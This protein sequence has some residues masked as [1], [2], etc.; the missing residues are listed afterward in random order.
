M[1][2]LF[3]TR[4]E[5]GLEGLEASI[6]WDHGC[7]GVVEEGPELVAWFDEIV[8]LPLEGTWE[9][10]PVVDYV[11]H[12]YAGL[13]PVRVGRLLIAP[14]HSSV[15]L[16]CPERPLWIDPGMAFGSGHHDTTVS[17]LKRLD[18]V[19]LSGKRV[20]DVGSG[21]GILAIA[22]D[23]LGA[24]SVLGVDNDAATLP[25]ARENA[26]LNGSSATFMKASLAAFSQTDPFA[27]DPASGDEL[28]WAQTEAV[29]V[30]SPGEPFDV[31]LAN[32]F[33]ELHRVLA[34][35]YRAHLSESGLLIASGVLQEQGEAAEASLAGHFTVEERLIEGDW[36]T[37]VARPKA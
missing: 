26:R 23:L 16:K 14:T 32:L 33:A 13:E 19:D 30:L 31:I 12:Y 9:T 15:T 22:A 20:L 35:A 18:L 34:P 1:T 17:V 29:P 36:I 7:N 11:A 27:I 21:S 28:D 25:V 10:P 2:F 3:R 37:L 6:L 5:H 24:G 4:A 8:T